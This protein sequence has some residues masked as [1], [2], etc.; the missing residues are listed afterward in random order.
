MGLLEYKIEMVCMIWD[1]IVVKFRA[2]L[3]VA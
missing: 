2:V 3:M 1:T